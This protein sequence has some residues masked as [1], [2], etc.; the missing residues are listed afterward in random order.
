MPRIAVIGTVLDAG[1]DL[2]RARPGFELA[3]TDGAD[4]AEVAALV[5]G[6]D[7]IIVRTARLDRGTLGV[8]RR[9]RVVSKHGVG[10]DNIAADLL[11][12]RGIPLTVVGDVNSVS[13]AEQ[14]L[15]MILGLARHVVAYDAAVRRGEYA[16]RDRLIGLELADLT[17]LLVGFGRIGRAVARRAA[18][19]DM[20][21]LVHAPTADPA[22]IRAA[23]CRPA[24]SLD[25]ALADADIVSLHA[26]LTEATRMM[27]GRRAL[28]LMK[29]SALLINCAR[30]GLVD[31]DALA[32][33][34]AAGRLAGAGLDTLAAE[35]PLPDSP[36]LASPNLLLSPHSGAWTTAS[37][38]RMAIAAAQNVLDAFDG[39]LDRALVVNAD[40][41]ASCV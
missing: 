7:G 12:E 34:L 27:I 41:I 35:P 11:S 5:R 30:G 8:A 16:V 19:F 39:T 13:V 21:V 4:P 31:E 38:R 17:L 33:A 6:A 25:A 9:L 10:W 22:A 36:L 3:L 40:Q 37:A 1:L 23:G 28:G 24:G 18:A 26:P 32:E 20:R 29:P 15:A 14:T 2:I